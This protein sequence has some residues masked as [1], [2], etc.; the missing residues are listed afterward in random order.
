MP[1]IQISVAE[2]TAEEYVR[3]RLDAGL[4]R[5]SIE[6]AQIA[7]PNSLFCVCVRCEDVLIGM[8]RVVGDGGCNFE[9]VDVA[10]HPHHQR[11]GLGYKIMSSLME[12]LL[13]NAPSSAY[14][15]L[16]ADEGA[17]SLYEKFGFKPTAPASIGMALVISK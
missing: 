12:Y 2:P 8:G 11:K 6:A 10:V 16:I 9:I 7:L 15:S 3:L 1:E 4:S 13:N 17:P 14:V 5:R